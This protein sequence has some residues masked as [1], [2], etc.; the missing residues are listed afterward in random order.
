MSSVSLGFVL[1]SMP[2]AR[3]II[4]G[5]MVFAIRVITIVGA[6]TTDKAVKSSSV[7]QVLLL[8]VPWLYRQETAQ[9]A[10]HMPEH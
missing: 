5:V 10:H 9:T 3:C 1:F 8:T 6:N 7:A 2:G 4:E